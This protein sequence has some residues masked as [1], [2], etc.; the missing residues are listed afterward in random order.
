MAFILILLIE[1]FLKWGIFVV[2]PLVSIFFPLLLALLINSFHEWKD[3]LRSS[4]L[5][6]CLPRMK[7]EIVM[8]TCAGFFAAAIN[9]AG[10]GAKI[11]AL[12]NYLVA[13][14]PFGISLVVA[15][16]L[17]SAA[18]IGIHPVVTGTAIM[19]SF[20]PEAFGV[21]PV[22]MATVIASSWSL[23]LIVSPFS[24][25]TVTMSG[26]YDRSPLEAGPKWHWLYTIIALPT[27]LLLLNGLR[28]LGFI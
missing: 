17:I 10:F 24:A 12:I 18:F 19:S 1:G 11:P 2:V 8:F 16:M 26:L 23:A 5:S 28:I 15:L 13:N 27:V 20:S 7:N 21:S 22:F 14:D 6:E 9:L 25:T 4:Y 3:L